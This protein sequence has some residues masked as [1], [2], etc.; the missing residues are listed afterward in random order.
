[1]QPVSFLF[2]WQVKDVAE[3]LALSEDINNLNV[4][5]VTIFGKHYLLTY[6]MEQSPS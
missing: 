5:Y 2:L 4:Q 1:M 6:S 3:N